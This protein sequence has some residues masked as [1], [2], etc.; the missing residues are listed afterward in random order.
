M[1]VHVSLSSVCL[2]FR[3]STGRKK[4]RCRLPGVDSVLK[5]LPVDEKDDNGEKC[6]WLDFCSLVNKLGPSVLMLL[7]WGG[8]GGH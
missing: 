6:K 3:R 4:K 8:R 1:A 5:S 7:D 2:V